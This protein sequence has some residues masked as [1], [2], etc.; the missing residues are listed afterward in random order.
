MFGRKKKSGANAEA[1]ALLAGFLDYQIETERMKDAARA[2]ERS[3]AI[4]KPQI[5]IGTGPSAGWLGGAAALPEGMAWPEQDGEKLLFLGQ[6]DLSALPPDLWDGAGPRSGWLAIFLPAQW[7]PQPTVLHFDGPLVEAQSPPP[8]SADWARIHDFKSIKTFALPK[9]PLVV[10][11]RPGNEI[12]EAGEARRVDKPGPGSL[13]D[14]AY[15]PFDPGTV[16]LLCEALDEAVTGMARQIVRFP[17]MKKL[18][19]ADAEW[20]ERQRS[21][22]LDT[23]VRFFQIEGRVRSN[24]RLGADEIA[25]FIGELAQLNA[26]DY[27]YLRNDEEGY[28]ELELRETKLLDPQPDSSDLRR[29][30]SR[31]DRGLT[32][33]AIKAYTADPAINPPPPV[34][35]GALRERLEAAWESETRGGLAAMGHAPQGHIYTPHGPGTPNEVLIKVHTSKLAGLIWADCYSLV[36]LIDREALRGG[37]FSGVTFDITN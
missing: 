34:L 19:P 29:W 6:I 30:W 8:N 37:D 33:H 20:F 10:E 26:C 9:W 31:Y 7:P 28:C 23:F 14:P 25:G 1:A 12:H 36:L 3:I 17:A 18:R 4:L 24:A 11:S 22:M 2:S 32:L 21:A 16:S 5:P 13:L 15:H 35:P 27:K